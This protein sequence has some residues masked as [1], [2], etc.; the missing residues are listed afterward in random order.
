V[1]EFQNQESEDRISHVVRRILRE[2]R[3]DTWMNSAEAA[4]YLRMSKHHL[5]RLCRG[6]LGPMAYGR[7][8]LAR[9]RRSALDEWQLQGGNKETAGQPN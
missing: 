3:A 6:G 2:E 8:R 9:W 7:G 1:T 4:T 5:L